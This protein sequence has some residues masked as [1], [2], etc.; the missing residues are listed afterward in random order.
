M[1]CRY[2]GKDNDS[3]NIKCVYCGAFLSE[4]DELEEKD[5]KEET[6]TAA[7]SRS[8]NFMDAS[9][10]RFVAWVSILIT[11]IACSI[12]VISAVKST[13]LHSILFD[14]FFI[15]FPICMIILTIISQVKEGKKLFGEEFSLFGNKEEK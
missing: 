5:D 4:I 1:K 12:F 13:N 2:C 3:N 15:V 11:T 10:F 6:D 8:R 14:I 9:T 7:S